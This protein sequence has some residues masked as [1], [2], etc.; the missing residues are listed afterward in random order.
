[1]SDS[2]KTSR[3]VGALLLACSP[4]VLA[5]VKVQSEVPTQAT[6]DPKLV[7]YAD[8]APSVPFAPSG[9]MGNQ[10][11]IKLDEKCT[12]NPHSGETCIKLQYMAPDKW[13][14]VIWQDPPNDWGDR[15]GGHNLTGATK[16]AFWARGEAGGER[17]KFVFGVIK[18]DKPNSDSASGEVEVVLTKA[19]TQYSID[20]TG[21][22]LSRIKTGFGWTVGGQGK[23]VTF[24]VDDVKYE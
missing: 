11:A 24:Y 19:W 22:D 9:W 4:A 12:Q 21:K 17:V 8:R 5:G 3:L 10:A 15:P 20:L 18:P 2:F 1:M 13:G 14:G 16:L 23:P 6:T 7:V